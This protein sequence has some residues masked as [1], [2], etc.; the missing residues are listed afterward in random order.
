MPE[1]STGGEML[2]KLE[3]NDRILHLRH[4]QAEPWRRYEEFVEYVLPDPPGFSKGI[5]TFMGLLK[6]DWQVLKS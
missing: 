6:K 5:A 2:W 4:N 1:I 3:G